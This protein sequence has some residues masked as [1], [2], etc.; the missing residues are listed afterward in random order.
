M[1]WPLRSP[2]SACPR[3]HD[4]D[5]ASL[6]NRRLVLIVLAWGA[7]ASF[8]LLLVSQGFLA[9]LCIAMLAALFWTSIMP[10]TEA[11]TMDGV[12]RAG[13]DYGRIR[14]WGSLTF[15]AASFA[16]GLVL[17]IWQAPAA[18]WL[19]IGAAAGVVLALLLAAVAGW[20]LLRG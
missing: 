5:T 6:D 7:F 17:D 9:I 8:L 12:R 1:L 18:L 15:I 19:L 11:V 13:F 3:R 2:R 4:P 16:G 14:L 10:L 20:L